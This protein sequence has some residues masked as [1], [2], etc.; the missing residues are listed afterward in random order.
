VYDARVHRPVAQ[1]GVA[2]GAEVPLDAA[3]EPGV[4]ES[5]VREPQAGVDE[6]KLASPALVEQ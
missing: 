6:E 5:E 1:C 4:G 3:S 2:G